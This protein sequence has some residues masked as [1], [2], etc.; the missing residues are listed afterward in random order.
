MSNYLSNK[1]ETTPGA[2]IEHLCIIAS[3]VFKPNQNEVLED[4]ICQ[5]F[6]KICDVLGWQSNDKTHNLIKEAIE[7]DDHSLAILMHQ[8]NRNGFVATVHFPVCSDFYFND[9]GKEP[10]RWK[11]STGY[12]S[13]DYLYADSIAELFDKIVTKSKEYFK[14]DLEKDLEKATSK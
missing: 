2:Y 14:K 7:D 10:K 11:C 1:L 6:D 3:E 5:P 9:E 8:N 13:V 4:F 12:C